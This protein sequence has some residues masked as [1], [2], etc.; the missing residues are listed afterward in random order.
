MSTAD[1]A[2]LFIGLAMDEPVVRPIASGEVCVFTTPKPQGGTNEDCAAVIPC[3]PT[4]AAL[5]VADGMGGHPSGECASRVAVECFVRALLRTNGQRPVRESILDAFDEANRRV[6]ETCNGSGTTA[7][8]AQVEGDTVRLYHC[9]DSGA[10]VVAADGDVVLRTLD[11]SPV[12]YAVQS[13]AL[14]PEEAMRH[15]ERHF[16]LNFLGNRE[17]RIEMSSR[18]RLRAGDTL[19]L[20]SDGLFDNLLDTEIAR[21]ARERPLRA[22]VRALVDATRARMASGPNGVACKPDD[23]TVIAFR[24]AKD[25]ARAPDPS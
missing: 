13:G 4:R 19:L 16:L 1:R 24:P 3:G 12:G 10:I 14:T 25:A 18:R 7:I 5:L 9:G 17:M 6:E 15:R 21:I 11:H 2:G 22:A 23:L 20:A 8:T